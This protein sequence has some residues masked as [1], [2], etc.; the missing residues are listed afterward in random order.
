MANQRR[1]IKRST[2]IY[3]VLYRGRN[4]RVRLKRERSSRPMNLRPLWK[5]MA[6]AGI[7]GLK[8]A[9]VLAVLGS[10]G[11]GGYLAYHQL[12]N[13][14][15]FRIQRVLVEGTERASDKEIAHQVRAFMG[16]HIFSA[17]LDVA[18]RSVLA[19]PW[20]RSAEV[21]RHFP[22]TLTVKVREYRP[23][24]LL[25][26]GHLYLVSGEGD[27]FKRATMSETGELPVITGMTRRD[28]LSHPG[29][30]RPLIKRAL[31]ALDRYQQRPRPAL[32]EVRISPQGEVTLFLKRGGTALRLGK[33]ITEERLNKLDAVWAA[34][35][36]Q[37]SKA[38]VLFLNNRSRMDRV[39][40][41]M[42]S[43]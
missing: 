8:V 18:Q 35:G 26:L 42:G 22:N 7:V 6:A 30:A 21:R 38:R 34:L 32:S 39:T 25:L 11:G 9:G 24:A 20:I 37:A 16:Q 43:L 23:R 27:V 33:R 31:D 5:T 4:R 15:T 1:T 17:E 19:H 40:V 14:D 13:A 41:R 10:A 28:Y 29:A 3:R 2:G 12:M 36:S